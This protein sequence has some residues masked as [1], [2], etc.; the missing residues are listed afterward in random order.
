MKKFALGVVV[1]GVISPVALT[2]AMLK[3]LDRRGALSIQ[4]IKDQIRDAFE[5]ARSAN[6]QCKSGVSETGTTVFEVK[7]RI[8]DISL[9]KSEAEE[10]IS[11]MM[12][13]SKRHGK[14]SVAELFDMVNHYSDVSHEQMGWTFGEL[15]HGNARVT[16]GEDGYYWLILPTPKMF[17]RPS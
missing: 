5:E 1:G 13:V 2:T 17:V 9:L 11:Q 7:K 3:W 12:D 16:E 10:V 14:V 8:E 15:R 6:A 4:D